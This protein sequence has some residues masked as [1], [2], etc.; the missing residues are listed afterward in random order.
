[1]ADYISSINWL[2]ILYLVIMLGMVYQG[3]RAGVGNQLLSLAWIFIVIFLSIG[4][5]VSFANNAF[6]FMKQCYARPIAFCIIAGMLFLL[7][8]FLEKIFQADTVE[9][10]SPFERILGSVI[11]GIRACLI[12]GVISIFLLLLPFGSLR[13][14]VSVESNSAMFFT[15]LDVNIYCWLSDKL[16]IAKDLKVPE[17]IDTIMDTSDKGIRG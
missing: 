12:F 14:A 8:M 11:A 1:L 10:L 13:K 15:T 9:A 4:F 5:Y 17:V 16:D 2:D 3:S 7:T 6:G